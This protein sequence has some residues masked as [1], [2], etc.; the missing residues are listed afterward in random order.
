MATTIAT[1][2]GRLLLALAVSRVL[3]AL[4][5]ALHDPGI[6]TSGTKLPG[7][8]YALEALLFAGGAALLWGVRRHD[9]RATHLSLAFGLVSAAFARGLLVAWEDAA[10]AIWW[11]ARLL[12]AL[13]LDAFLP[14]AI[15]RFASEFPRGPLLGIGRRIQEG[16][17]RAS[18]IVGVI[19]AVGDLATTV[20]LLPPDYA[21]K[22]T[23][24]GLYWILVMGMVLAAIG[25]M[26][27]KS[28]RVPVAEKRKARLFL[29]ALLFGTTPITIAI[30]VESLFPAVEAFLSNR[31]YRLA[32]GLIVLPPML[33]IP[34]TTAYAVVVDR[35]LDIR[36]VVRRALQYALAR[37]S[38]LS[39]IALPFL[40]LALLIASN[41]NK[42]L[43]DVATG[44]PSAALFLLGAAAIAAY[45]SRDSIL[46]ALD[47]KYFREQYDSHRILTN[48]VE[49]LG[50]L[51]SSE[52][53]AS[54]LGRQ[55]DK[56]LHVTAFDAFLLDWDSGALQ[57]ASRNMRPLNPDGPLARQLHAAS[58]PVR[59][60]FER[61]GPL[62]DSLSDEDRRWLLDLGSKLLVPMRGAENRLFGVL[63]LGEKKSELPFSTSDL[64][65]LARVASAGAL[66]WENQL[67][68]SSAP[69]S[70]RPLAAGSVITAHECES[71]YLVVEGGAVACPECSGSLRPAI[72]PRD[73]FGKF[74]LE[75]R[76]GRGGMGV[77]YLGVD[78]SLHR[79]VA[80]K[81]LPRM[82]SARASRLR[83]EARTMA[84]VRHANLALIYGLESWEGAPFLVLEYLGGGTLS[85]RIS[86]GPLEVEE[87]VETTLRICDALEHTHQRGFLHR[88]IKPSNIGF[89]QDGSP[90]LLDF[91][92]AYLL[93][94]RRESSPVRRSVDASLLGTPSE[95]A[96]Q[97]IASA[98]P[99]GRVAGTPL[100][101]SPE[102][103]LRRTPGPS[104]DLWALA[105]VLFEALAGRHPLWTPGEPFGL[106]RILTEEV[107]D[108][109]EFVPDCPPGLAETLGGFLAG[110]ES[111][112]PSSASA[113]AAQLRQARQGS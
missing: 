109:R 113:F 26:S 33:L 108:I 15:W 78:L 42:P 84:A 60:E 74:R 35:A 96:T 75:R 20:G 10:P 21:L 81:A 99:F 25:F 37:Y 79:E 29:S 43:V 36:L 94:E 2:L 31:E 77:V 104:F 58:R 92:L 49:Q 89:D 105:L 65:L 16:S 18:L 41:R 7:W 67:L 12:A 1:A 97:S 44:S 110:R 19:L 22:R 30:F 53:M 83:R 57:S 51:D 45:R 95:E 14:L 112:R 27:W 91:G 38:I 3:M 102:A 88:D 63:S 50:K 56:A 101:L 23:P 87:A 93:T 52:S 98:T 8:V 34:F 71:C 5:G 100:Y 90:K 39:L 73:L 46:E 62:I 40:G 9:A 106:G 4:G 111:K 68:R 72:L 66:A 107:P 103:V 86:R 80:I 70:R 61:P 82:D 69:G 11:A 59:V 48:M 13:P 6:L 17:L 32:V 24:L 76:I 85:E 54:L 55:I 47:R 64:R 28:G